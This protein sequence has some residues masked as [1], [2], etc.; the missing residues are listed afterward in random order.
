MLDKYE[1]GGLQWIVTPQLEAAGPNGTTYIF[2]GTMTY[3]V[4]GA[5]NTVD[6]SQ[7]LVTIKPG[8]S[9]QVHYFWEKHVQGEHAKGE[10]ENALPFCFAVAIR[11]SGAQTAEKLR[12]V[13]P[14][15][16]V[17]EEEKGT[18]TNYRVIG[19]MLGKEDRDHSLEVRYS[20]LLS[21]FI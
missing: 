9:L 5:I 13:S 12:V 7:T 17:I 16:E 6:L 4:L 8:P 10:K 2:G 21:R 1:K 19:S 14:Q 18:L 11:N 20:R 3:H 15:L